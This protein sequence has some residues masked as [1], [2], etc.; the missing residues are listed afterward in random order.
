MRPQTGAPRSRAG[1]FEL[2]LGLPIGLVIGFVIVELLGRETRFA[3]YGLGTLLALVFAPRV[4]SQVGS[5][6]R[7]LFAGLVLALQ[8]D[9]AVAFSFREYKVAGPYGYLVSP[10]LLAAAA[11]FAVRAALASRRLAA[12]LATDGPLLRAFGLMLLAG[13]LSALN[14]SDR[15]LLGFGILE[16]LTLG[17]LAAVTVDQCSRR[18]GLDLVQRLL[19]WTLVLQSALIIIGFATG[20]Q[21]SLSAGTRGA[22][23]GWASSGRFSGTMTTPSAAGTMLFVCLIAAVTRLYQYSA[24]LDR[25]WLWFQIGLGS[26]ALLL[27]QTRTA[28]IGLILGGGGVLLAAVRRGDLTQRRLLQLGGV[29][30]VAF[31]AAWPFVAS[32]VTEDHSDDAEVRWHLVLVAA[33]MIQAHPLLGIGLNTATHQVA[34]YAARAGVGGWVFIVHNQFLLVWAETGI[35]GLLGFLGLFRVALRAASRLSREADVE[36]RNVGLWLFWSFVALIWALSMDHVSGAPTYK[37]VFFLFGV[38]VGAARL[39]RMETSTG[40]PPHAE[41]S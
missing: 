3:I 6:E 10:V 18:E 15:Q 41:A 13:A 30:F 24:P 36:L 31:L 40:S 32:R 19:G 2:L 39:A 29:V 27:T 35:L 23:Y 25:A 22:D 20:V 34:N 1:S 28:W 11:L 7:L 8:L 14:A 21:I 9:V 16:L 33:E 12:P 26:F 5:L 37:L 17:L 38:A 4:V